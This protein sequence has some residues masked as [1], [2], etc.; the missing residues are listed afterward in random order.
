MTTDP[1]N[2]RPV[3]MRALDIAF[4][5]V[6]ADIATPEITAA[7]T[8]EGADPARVLAHALLSA[9]NRL[10]DEIGRASCRERV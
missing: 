10:A 8:A 7:L 9:M 3:L 4:P 2:D 1:N 6:E 5:I